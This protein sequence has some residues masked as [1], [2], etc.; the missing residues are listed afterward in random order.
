MKVCKTCKIQKDLT[1]FS[2]CSSSKDGLQFR[3]K[4]CHAKWY[5]ANRE[6][7]TEHNAA[8]R[9]RIAARS[10]EWR[11]ANKERIAAKRA[12]YYA[13]NKR[14]I[15]AQCVKYYAANREKFAEYNAKYYSENRERI[16]ESGAKYYVANRE[17]IAERKRENPEQSAAYSRNR[18]ARERKADGKHTA[19]DIARIFDRQNGRCA[20]C[21]DRLVKSG[22]QKFHVDHIVPLAKGGS[23]WPANLQCL[24]PAC[25][26]RKHAKD[27]IEW[28]KSNGRLL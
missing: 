20:N 10:A 19:A 26:L 23:N 1:E 21:H 6:R 11:S 14:R 18:R 22:K 5:A 7:I 8:N 17:T 27:P 25:N 15:N 13:S 3:C 12:E 4:A 2:K 24:C 28:A 16:S 9:E